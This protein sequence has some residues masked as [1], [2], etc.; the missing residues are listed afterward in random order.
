VGGVSVARV[1]H[2]VAPIR[3]ANKERRSTDR[4]PD[5]TH[6]FASLRR[7]TRTQLVPPTPPPPVKPDLACSRKPPL[8]PVRC[9]PPLTP[10]E[11]AP[12]PARTPP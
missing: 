5:A 6:D 10:R 7:T 1:V 8:R 3:S 11:T 2:S 12:A 4:D 9:G